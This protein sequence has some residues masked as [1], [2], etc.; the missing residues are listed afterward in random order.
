MIK[1]ESK[2]EY[3]VT[4][5]PCS[6][7]V[8]AIYKIIGATDCYYKIKVNDKCTG[9]VNKK[10]LIGRGSD[11]RYYAWTKEKVDKYV[12]RAKLEKAVNAVEV[13]KLSIEQLENILKII[14]E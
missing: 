11:I 8:G 4:Y 12:Y 9:L 13:S 14:K 7:R 3:L 1:C 6:S 10:T 5:L 2:P